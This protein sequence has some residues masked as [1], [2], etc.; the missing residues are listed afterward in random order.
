MEMSNRSSSYMDKSTAA[1]F[2]EAVQFK[3][4]NLGQ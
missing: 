2:A 1:D 4:L 3:K